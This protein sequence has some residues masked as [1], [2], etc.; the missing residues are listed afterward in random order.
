MLGC[1]RSEQLLPLDKAIRSRLPEPNTRYSEV[2][3][4]IDGRADEPLY[5]AVEPEVTWQSE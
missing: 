5:L 3:I 2:L 4:A 1:H